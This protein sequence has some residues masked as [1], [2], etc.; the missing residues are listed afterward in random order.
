MI[1]GAIWGLWHLPLFFIRGTT[2]SFL[3]F[4]PFVLWVTG[5][6]IL[7]TWVYDNTTGSLLIPVL[8]HTTVN[9]FAAI[10]TVLPKDVSDSTCPFL[11]YILL[12]CLLTAIVVCV[13]GPRL[14]SKTRSR[15]APP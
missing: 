10:L 5:V 6:S 4:V 8:L 11:L 9:F 12:V 15:A 1:L 13:T 14:S 2:Q 3:A 7:F